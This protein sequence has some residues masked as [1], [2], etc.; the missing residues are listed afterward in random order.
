MLKTHQK[1]RE[2]LHQLTNKRG[3]S[4]HLNR[5]LALNLAWFLKP[6]VLNGS[7]GIEQSPLVY[8]LHQRSV[9]QLATYVHK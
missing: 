8:L 6:N 3:D 9:Q 4:N 5:N 2:S 7:N 1:E